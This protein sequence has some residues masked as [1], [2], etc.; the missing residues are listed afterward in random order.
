[1]QSNILAQLVR[2]EYSSTCNQAVHVGGQTYTVSWHIS[3]RDTTNCG[4]NFVSDEDCRTSELERPMFTL[5][6]RRTLS[7]IHVRRCSGKLGAGKFV[8]ERVSGKLPNMKVK[9]TKYLKSFHFLIT[10]IWEVHLKTTSTENVVHF[11]L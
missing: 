7:Q 5:N 6:C 8:C 1:M 11:M 3:F 9:Y 2:S 4:T 10:E